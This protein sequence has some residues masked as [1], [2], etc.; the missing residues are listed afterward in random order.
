MDFHGLQVSTGGEEMALYLVTGG[1]GF[2]GSSMVRGILQ[3]G[4]RVRVLDNFVTGHRSNLADVLQQIELCEADVTDLAR[5]RVLDNF[6]T[7]HRSNLAEVLHQIELCEADV[8][9]LARLS[10]ACEGADYVLHL[11]ALASVPRS[12]QDPSQPIAST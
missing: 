11:A 6:A 9:D 7:G 4:G 1:A 10:S 8:T 12:V 5:V 2:I 3:R